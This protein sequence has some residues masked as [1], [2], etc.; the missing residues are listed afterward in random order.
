[1]PGTGHFWLVI[2]AM[3]VLAATIVGVA[4]FRR[5]I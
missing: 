4:R 2:A 5:W 3:L 1:M